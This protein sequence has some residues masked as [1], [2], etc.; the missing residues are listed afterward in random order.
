MKY[1]MGRTGL[2]AAGIVAVVAGN[3]ST[4]CRADVTISSKPTQNMSCSSGVCTPT[5]KNAV[6]N[7]GDL[8]TML[9]SE[10]VT[11]NTAS[12]SLAKQVQNIDVSDGFTWAS[13]KSLTLD[14]YNSV[15]FTKPVSVAG[16]GAVVLKTNDGGTKGNLSFIA[17]GSLSFLGTANS[18]TVNGKVYTL[19]N[20]IA[21]LA[22]DIEGNPAGNYAL[23]ANYSAKPDGAYAAAPVSTTF[24]GIFNGLGNTISHMT[25]RTKAQNA[26][27]GLFADVAK[28]GTIDSLRIMDASITVGPN[29]YVGVL[30]GNSYGI[31]D[32]SVVAGSIKAKAG[33]DGVQAGGI[34]GVNAGNLVGSSAATNIQV[35]GNA[36][37][38]GAYVGGVVGDNQGMIESSYATGSVVAMNGVVEATSGGLV[39]FN[40][41]AISDCY[42]TGA[43]SVDASTSAGGLV[44]YNG[45][46]VATSYSTGI[47]STTGAPVGGSIGIDTTNGAD[48]SDIYWDTT[49]S[50]I[51]NLSQGAG[52]PANDPGI[53]GQTTAQ[54]QA[55]LPAGFDPTIWAENPSI[56]NGLPYLIANPPQ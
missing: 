5:A 11:V 10:N 26:N 23:S 44:G 4:P 15:T 48:L 6:L 56:N 22:T 24:E 30:A 42:A 37:I 43:A 28:T 14:A 32:N 34:L 2:Y 17:K 12:G 47:P 31:V 45:L 8:T 35:T 20:S 29:S 18:L 40:N 39:G 46:T 53:T 9:A 50:G 3:A 49:T 41:G 21:S 51:T 19:V 27:I 36:P 7:V 55:G 16:A 1:A 33:R 25:I 52:S 13:A 38:S 54:L